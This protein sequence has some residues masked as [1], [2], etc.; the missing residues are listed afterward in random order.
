M[1]KD[2]THTHEHKFGEWEL[3]DRELVS[4]GKYKCKFVRHC[5]TCNHT[6]T[7]YETKVM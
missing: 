3:V 6:E 7:K 4:N 2:W 1:S 5:Y